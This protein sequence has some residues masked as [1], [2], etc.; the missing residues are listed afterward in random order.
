M[1]RLWSNYTAASHRVMFLPGALLTVLAMLWWLLDLE[2]RRAGGAGLGDLPG[3]AL[4]VWWMLYGF[5]PFFIFGFLFT[6]APNWLNGPAIPRRAYVASGVLMALGALLVLAGLVV[7]GLALHLAGW[8]VAVWAL[9][10][11]LTGAPP[12]D[13]VHPA[14]VTAAAA[15]GGVGDAV[16]LVW[17][18]AD[19]PDALRMAEAIGV[20]GFLVPTFLAV[21]HRMIPWFT[22]RIV[23]NY[24]MVRPYGP[25]WGVLA[26]CLVHGALE[27]M[28]RRELLWLVD[29]PMA[30]TVFWFATR[31]GV[32][33]GAQQVRLLSML[34]IGFLWLGLSLLLYSLDS[35]ARYGGL[36]WNAGHAPLHALGIGYFSSMLIGMA[37]RVS[38]GHSGRKLEADATIWGL[39]WL[40]QG[41][42]LLRL[43]P[44]LLPGL[45]TL[46]ISLAGGLW[47]LAFGVWA[48]K[49]APTYWRPRVDGKPG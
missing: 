37:S 24:V 18:G 19:F 30:V 32:A 27:V 42:A 38:L 3:P 12:Q 16:F 35:L 28:E 1:S 17:A 21:C 29:L 49:F 44:D 2:S 47:L 48:G 45:P 41:V 14:I 34:H 10:R 43:L 23:P 26:G 40:V 5:F 6:A 4:H 39:F 8:S 11:T 36:A 46:L 25:L 9:F 33:R 31:W 22:S 15:L 13:K 20:W 7:P